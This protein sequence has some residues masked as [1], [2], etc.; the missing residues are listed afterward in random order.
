[1]IKVMAMILA[2]KKAHTDSTDTT[3]AIE[4][5]IRPQSPGFGHVCIDPL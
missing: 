1:M 2:T 3:E 4:R 5:G